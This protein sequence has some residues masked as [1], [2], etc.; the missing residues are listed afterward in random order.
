LTQPYAPASAAQEIWPAIGTSSRRILVVDDNEDAALSMGLLLEQDG[1]EVQYA[2]EGRTALDIAQAFQPEVALLDIGLPGLDGFEVAQ[3]LRDRPE[4]AGALLVAL[5]GYGQSED[6][7]RSQAAG[8]DYHLVK[9]VD[10]QKLL[11]LIAGR[12]VARKLL[13]QEST[14]KEM[15]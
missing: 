13:A 14:E 9:P 10:P 3:Q 15:P 4:T 7:E 11:A 12:P 5:T 2:Y 6:R 8:F 1:H